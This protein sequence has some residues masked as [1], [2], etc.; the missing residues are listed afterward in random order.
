[1]TDANLSG[2]NAAKTSIVN[3]GEANWQLNPAIQQTLGDFAIYWEEHFALETEPQQLTFTFEA[4]A[5]DAD[6][7]FKFFVGASNIDLTFDRVEMINTSLSEVEKYVAIGSLLM[8][9]WT[10]FYGSKAIN[11][12]DD[13]CYPAAP[14]EQAL[15]SSFETPIPGNQG[16]LDLVAYQLGGGVLLRYRQSGEKLQLSVS[17]F[18]IELYFLKVTGPEVNTTIRFYKR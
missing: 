1:M 2:P 18:K 6:V 15:L 8:G 17:T 16:E 3:S 12:E 11:I 13:G 7:W 4:S 14:T 5:T 10:R 9:K